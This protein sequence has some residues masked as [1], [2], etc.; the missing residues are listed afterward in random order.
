MKKCIYCSTQISIESVVD[1]CKGCM[2]KVWGPKMANA[3]VE[4]MEKEKEKGNMELGRVSETTGIKHENKIE[5]EMS[6]SEDLSRE[7][8]E[9]ERNSNLNFV[10]QKNMESE[11]TIL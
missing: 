7:L 6:V 2:Y 1:M 9:L 8:E 4:G 11:L 3:I 10:E 5:R